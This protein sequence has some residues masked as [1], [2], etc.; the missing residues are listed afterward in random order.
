MG[1]IDKPTVA[2][3][4]RQYKKL[5]AEGYRTTTFIRVQA[6]NI[7]VTPGAVQRAVFGHTHKDVDEEPP[8]R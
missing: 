8:R 4:R 5:R 2:R 6:R 3:L 1:K 7:G